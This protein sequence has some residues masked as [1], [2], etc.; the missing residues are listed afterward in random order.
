MEYKR[1]DNQIAVRLDCGDE[2]SES[3][4]KIA[5]AEKITLGSV[6][7]IGATDDVDVG[8]FDTDAKTY[9]RYTFTGTHEITSLTG[10]LTTKDGK[11]YSHLHITL[12]GDGGKITGGHL[13]RGMISLTAEIFITVID[14]K[15]ERKYDSVYGINK[16]AF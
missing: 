7:G 9:N 10:N 16:I 2:I 3:I 15:A 11:P 8:V 1:F 4:L 5:E 13:L 12:A 14:G 6:S